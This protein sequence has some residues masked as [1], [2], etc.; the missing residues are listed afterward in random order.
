MGEVYR[1]TDTKLKRQVAIKILP[2]VFAADHDRLARF[3]REAEVLA[4]LNHSNIAH[5]HGLEESGGITALVMEL[6]EGEDLSQRIARGAVPIDE[7]LPIAKQIAEALEAAHEQ[8]IIHRDLKPANVK[9]RSDGTVMVLDFGLAKAMDPAAASSPGMSVSPTITTPA[10]TQ[11]G[12]ILGTAAYMSP[13]QARGKPVDR[14][15][16][17]WAFGAVLF[18]MLSGTR[19]FGGDDVAETLANV[20]NK[21][22]A[23]ER[24][25]AE[26]PARIRQVLRACLQKSPKQRPGDMQSVRLALE[27]AFESAA[28]QATATSTTP[29]SGR[30]WM[31][32]AGASL[33]TALAVLAVTTLFRTEAPTLPT[34]R[35]EFSQPTTPNPVQ[36]AVSPDGRYMVSVAGTDK[37]VALWLRAFEGSDRFLKDTDNGQ[38]PFWS[39]DSRYIG[40]FANKKLKMIDIT[41]GGPARPIADTT[42][43]LGGSWSEDGIIVFA[44]DTRGPIYRV[45]ATGGTPVAVT[46]LDKTLEETV[47]VGP[48]FLPGGNRFI[49]LAR[50]SKPENDFIVYLGSLDSKERKKLVDSTGWPGFSP[51]GYL[52]FQRATTL[53]AQA[54]QPGSFDLTGVPQIVMEG[55]TPGSP[56]FARPGFSASRNGVLVARLGGANTN[57]LWWFTRSSSEHPKV[58]AAQEYLNPRLS[59]DGQRVAGEQRE[60]GGGDIWLFDLARNTSTRFTFT[61]ARDSSPIWSPDG[62]R[63][64]FASNRDGANGIYVK[65]AGGALPEELLLKSEFP[66]APADWSSDGKYIV[67]TEQNPKTKNDIRILPVSGERKPIPAVQTPFEES[68]GQFSPDGRWVAYESTESGT[69]EVYVQSFPAS[70]NKWKISNNGGYRPQWRRDGK[71]LFYSNISNVMSVDIKAPKPF[72]QFEAG[73]PQLAV[74]ARTSG[75]FSVTADGQHF[76]VNGREADSAE[77]SALTVIVNWAAALGAR[78]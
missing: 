74:R 38:D 32:A 22:P 46:E 73:I 1:A 17:I 49:Y 69:Y 77:S 53:L 37:G 27:G 43:G 31:V 18:E 41:G 13:E 34:M 61:D 36:F 58:I 23:W 12:M 39:P 62:Q 51:P 78:K 52:L 54:L 35:F 16:D 30:V 55:L 5:I 11:A 15:A 26:V 14:R 59:P 9:V 28:P 44:R 75:A 40:F 33:L 47:H 68:G 6:V 71:E 19:A 2:P 65:N 20:I 29:R 56:N 10:M 7:A 8:G 67:Y 25:P 60:S 24:L 76:L 21:E 63:I 57:Q 3:Q 48:R 72:N 70:G 50:S 66:L 64:A 45:A 4:S 42:G